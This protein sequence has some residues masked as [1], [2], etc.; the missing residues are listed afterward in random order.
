MV[1]PRSDVNSI[2][3]FVI[4]ALFCSPTGFAQQTDQSR[5]KI[6]L[7]LSGGGARGAAHVG[8]IKVLDSLRIPVDYI[9]GTS[10]GAIVGGLYASGMSAKKL[11]QVF[12]TADWTRLLSDKPPRSQ[13]TLRR[14]NDDAGFLVDFDIGLRKG[15]FLF[16]KGLIQGQILSL[17]LRRLLKNVITVDD[18]DKLPIPFRAIAANIATG[19]E[20][21]MGSGDLAKSIRASMSVPGIFKPVDIDGNLLVDGG[22][23]NNLPIDIVKEMGADIVVVIDVGTSPFDEKELNS[24][25]KITNQMLTI[26]INTQSKHKKQLMSADDIL[27]TPEL[28]QLSSRAFEKSS[29]AIAIGEHT[30]RKSISEL[31][32][33][34]LGYEEY[35]DYRRSLQNNLVDLPVITQV[36]V[37]NQSRLSPRIIQHRLSDHTNKPLDLDT[38][39]SEISAIYGFDTFESVDYT[40]VKNESGAGLNIKSKSKDWG[41]NYL[42]FGVNLED[43]FKGDS[44][45]NLAASLTRTEVNKLGGELRTDFVIG[46]EPRFSIELYQPLDYATRW[47]VNPALRYQR[48]SSGL[49]EDGNQLALLRSEDSSVSLGVGRN[50]GNTSELRL[51]L[52]RSFNSGGVQIG[53]PATPAMSSDLT[54][55]SLGYQF[56]TIDRLA[57]PRFGSSFALSW[58]GSRKGFGADQSV[59]VVSLFLLKPQ[60]WGKNTL[61]HWWNLGGVVNEGDIPVEVFSLGGFFNLSGYASNE[62]RG[63]HL[64]LGRVL[65]YRHLNDGV[66]SLLDTPV[67]LGASIE[68]GNVWQESSEISFDNIL[69]AG[70]LFL[71]IDTVIGPLYLA[72]GSAEGGRDAAYLFLGQTF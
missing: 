51:S 61:L 42:R 25:L 38:L 34:S 48:S 1:F 27:I 11:E 54:S 69:T 24:P 21:V 29:Q 53:D 39:E 60:T 59:D 45:Y 4:L 41:P 6:G 33:L 46:E 44:N 63:Q 2:I 20:V 31:S 17:E 58:G 52:I 16:P 12:D 72:Y 70:S 62:L 49:F 35:A 10:M 66:A 57:I 32:R 9:A 23:V 64:A 8:A 22:I 71:V 65:Y 67:Y 36:T 5:Q 18:F 47:F 50:F 19:E 56:D 14:K 30:T 68:G 7:V 43:N 26:L 40:V 28:G 15:K 37:E 55:F 3:Y 13:R